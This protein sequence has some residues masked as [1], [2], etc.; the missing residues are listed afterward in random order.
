M[1]NERII[2][3]F[4]M[5][6]T[7]LKGRLVLQMARI[8]GMEDSV[9]CIMESNMIGYARSVAIARLWKGLN[10]DTILE[11]LSGIEL[12]DN[13]ISTITELKRRGCIV[14]I[15]SDSYTLA[16]DYIAGMLGMHFSIANRLEYDSKGIL[17]GNVYMPLG[18]QYIGC[19]CLNSVCKRYQLTRTMRM[20]SANKSVAVGDSRNDTCMLSVA[21][22]SIAYNATDGIDT[23][24]MYSIDDLYS[25]IDIFRDEGLIE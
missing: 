19:G 14:G 4:D 10:K 24:S 6:R 20:Y 18:W 12:S 9:R 17:T 3:A 21:D 7:L 25:I 23:I 8:S 16:T 11:A 1:S 5:D 15:I 22:V 13:A 2:V